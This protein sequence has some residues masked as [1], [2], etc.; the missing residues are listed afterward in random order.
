MTGYT[1]SEEFFYR[2]LLTIFMPALL[3][4]VDLC[5]IWP[6]TF[7]VKLCEFRKPEDMKPLDCRRM[8]NRITVAFSMQI[9]F[10]YP[11]I[12]YTLFAST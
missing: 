6:L 2:L 9:F 10:I 1:H 11:A 12:L 5:M 8:C 4:A 3:L 7:F